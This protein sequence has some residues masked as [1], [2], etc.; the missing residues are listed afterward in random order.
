MIT[1][2]PKV[3][4]QVSEIYNPAIPSE[5]GS[6]SGGLAL[7]TLIASLWRAIIVLGGIALLLYLVWGGIEWIMAG[8]D[9]GKLESAKQ[10]MTQAVVGMAILAA[11]VAIA[12]FIGSILKIDLLNPTFFGPGNSYDPSSDFIFSRPADH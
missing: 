9:S 10:R 7:A 1:I 11:T 2:I 6:R 5:I 4:A 3:Q 8:S 12:V